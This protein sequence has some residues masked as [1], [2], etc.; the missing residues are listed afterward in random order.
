MDNCVFHML[1]LHTHMH[2][3]HVN[4]N[5]GYSFRVANLDYWDT[6]IWSG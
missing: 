5:R 3:T 1:Y 6:H 2:V 4:M